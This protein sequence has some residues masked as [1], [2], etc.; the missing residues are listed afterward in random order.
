MR[1]NFF[2]KESKLLT[3]YELDSNPFKVGEIINLN[4]YNHERV[5]WSSVEEVHKSYKI[6]NIEHYLTADYTKEIKRN[7]IHTVAIELSELI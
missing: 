3:F 6:E 7:I 5:I 2:T 4:I 1:I